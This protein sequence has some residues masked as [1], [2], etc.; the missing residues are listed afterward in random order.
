M[1]RYTRSI[2]ISDFDNKIIVDFIVEVHPDVSDVAASE[3]ID[4]ID[5]DVFENSSAYADWISFIANIE[6]AIESQNYQIMN[7]TTSSVSKILYFCN[8]I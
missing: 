5:T 7:H 4:I 8:H 6:E 3:I 1:K 2:T